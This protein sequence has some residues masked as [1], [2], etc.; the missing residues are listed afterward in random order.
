MKAVCKV[1]IKNELYNDTKYFIFNLNFTLFK[2]PIS[3]DNFV[4]RLSRRFPT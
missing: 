4:D 3:L 2:I 1:R